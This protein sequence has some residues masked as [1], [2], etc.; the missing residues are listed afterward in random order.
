[1]LKERLQS[2][3]N[4]YLELE[5]RLSEPEIFKNQ[6]QYQLLTKEH[7]DLN[8]LVNTFRRFQQVEKELETNQTLLK[9]ETDEEI[10]ELARE[11]IQQL[12]EKLTELEEELRLLLLP[13][14]PND[15]KNILLEIRAGT[16]GEEAALFAADLFRM[17]G[18]FAERHQLKIGN[19]QS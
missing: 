10:K 1:M 11:E 18:R 4:K 19:P 8:L 2:L 13:K 7:A 15:E 9:T 12:K 17:Y 14:D 6:E 16:G 3:E 5:T